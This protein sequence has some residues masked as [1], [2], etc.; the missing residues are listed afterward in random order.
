MPF[1]CMLE[2]NGTGYW[3]REEKHVS[4][5]ELELLYDDKLDPHIKHLWGELRVYFDTK[6]WDVKKDG[7]IYTD[8][9]F[10]DDLRGCL[11]T[12]GLVDKDVE[13][14]EQGMQG[15]NFVSL[16]VGDDFITSWIFKEWAA[17]ELPGN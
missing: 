17:T 6:T 5:I 2:T 8:R 16:D 1:A 9:Q 11:D 7:L 15:T 3:S 10:I 4:V 13:Y 14:S 12:A